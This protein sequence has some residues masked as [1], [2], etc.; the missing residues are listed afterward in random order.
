MHGIA[1]GARRRLA[2][3]EHPGSVAARLRQRRWN[4]VLERFPDLGEMRVLDLGGTVEHW[5]HCPVRPASLTVLNLFAQ[6]SSSDSVVVAVGDA[7]SPPPSIESETFDLVYS[8]SVLEHVGGHQRRA[9]MADVVTRLGDRHW[10]Q[11]PNRYFPIEPHW[12]FPMFQYLPVGARAWI[13]ERWPLGYYRGQGRQAV[14]EVLST[15]LI[16][17]KEMRF[18]FPDSTVL[19]ERVLGCPKSLIAIG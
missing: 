12:L 19:A 2:D 15:E 1:D 10:V 8:N 3:S 6:E 16:G 9:E 5:Q 14:E 4:Q 7:C 18:L 13:T 17:P 11:T